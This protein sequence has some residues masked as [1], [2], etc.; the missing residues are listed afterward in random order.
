M[1]VGLSSDGILDDPRFGE[2]DFSQDGYSFL[3]FKFSATPAITDS[4]LFSTF[5]LGKNE[6]PAVRTRTIGISQAAF[7]EDGTKLNLLALVAYL[8]R[9]V[10]ITMAHLHLGAEGEN[11]PVVANL[12]SDN[13]F[14]T[15][16]FRRLKTDVES[17]DLVGP[18]L[19]QQLDTLVAAIQEGRVYVNIH[20]DR[21]PAGEVRGQLTEVSSYGY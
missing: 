4:L 21:N 18:L 12:L 8:P 7:I 10:D 13:S 1:A 11:G 9:D 16:G 2:A 6:V 17:S 3:K 19:G 14:T 20:T 5:L 15:S